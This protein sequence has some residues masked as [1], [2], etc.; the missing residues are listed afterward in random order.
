MTPVIAG[1]VD[2]VGAEKVRAVLPVLR[3]LRLQ[4]SEND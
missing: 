4:L 3:E 2:K 1:L